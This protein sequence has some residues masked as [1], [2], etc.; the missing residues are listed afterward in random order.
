MVDQGLDLRPDTG[1]RLQAA[2]RTRRPRIGAVFRQVRPGIALRTDADCGTAG[3]D[4]RGENNYE[5]LAAF[6]R[7]IGLEGILLP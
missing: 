2:L 5:E 3:Q 1:T 6:H 4:E 7:S